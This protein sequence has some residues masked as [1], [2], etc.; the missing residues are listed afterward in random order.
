[1]APVAGTVRWLGFLSL[2]GHDLCY[3]FA[4][5]VLYVICYTLYVLCYMLVEST[6][7]LFRCS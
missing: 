2:G 6:T 5:Y 7:V 1:M 3:F 4:L